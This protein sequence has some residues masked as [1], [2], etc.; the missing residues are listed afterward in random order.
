MVSFCISNGRPLFASSA[1]CILVSLPPDALRHV[2]IYQCMVH[3]Q[4]IVAP[5]RIARYRFQMLLFYN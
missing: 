3:V 2:L 4:A 5:I 1:V